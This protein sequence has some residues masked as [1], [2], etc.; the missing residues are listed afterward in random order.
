M[1]KNNFYLRPD[2]IERNEM[3]CKG[4]KFNK[5]FNALLAVDNI[6][7]LYFRKMFKKG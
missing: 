4:L 6:L 2:K 3:C 1:N 7:Q 5:T